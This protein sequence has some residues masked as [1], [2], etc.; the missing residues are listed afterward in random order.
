MADIAR[1]A[2]VSPG[3]L[4]NYVESKEALFDLVLRGTLARSKQRPP[5]ALPVPHRTISQTVGWLRRRLNFSN[6]FPVLEAAAIEPHG[7]LEAVAAELFD[8]A[9]E[10]SPSFA[11]MERSAPDLPEVL[12]LF[13]SLRRGLIDRLTAFIESGS[14][15]GALRRVDA[16]DVTARLILEAMLWASQRRARDRESATVSDAAARAAFID[17]VV[18]TLAP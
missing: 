3:T 1:V 17:L 16:P 11:V 6:D 14:S 4:Y 18:A 12:S 7:Q 8:V 15:A 9:F 10:L 13:L 5:A 2:G